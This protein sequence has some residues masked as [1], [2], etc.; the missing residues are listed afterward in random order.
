VGRE[1]PGW[2]LEPLTVPGKASCFC[3]GCREQAQPLYKKDLDKSYFPSFGF[4]KNNN[5]WKRNQPAL[6]YTFLLCLSEKKS[7]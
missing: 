4:F 7:K 6:F 2:R 1:S 3:E 5:Q